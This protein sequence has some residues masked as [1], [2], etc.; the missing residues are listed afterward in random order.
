M[1]NLTQSEKD[2]WKAPQTLL[3][4]LLV[5]KSSSIDQIWGK[6]SLSWSKDT[7]NIPLLFVCLCLFSPLSSSQQVANLRQTWRRGGDA[8]DRYQKGRKTLASGIN[9]LSEACMSQI[10]QAST[11]ENQIS[12]LGSSC[13]Q[14]PVV[15]SPVFSFLL[16]KEKK[17][18]TTA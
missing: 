9:Y 15:T 12:S 13:Q 16:Y 6:N 3:E 2:C 4:T 1:Q 18:F 5:Q 14:M 11:G 10:K 17:I 8:C 7:K